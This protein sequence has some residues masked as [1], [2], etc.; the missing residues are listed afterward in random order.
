MDGSTSAAIRTATV[1]ALEADATVT[2]LVPA[3]RIFDSDMV[4]EG[5]D[6]PFI[7]VW[8]TGERMRPAGT[9]TYG[10]P[11][12]L[13]ETELVVDYEAPETGGE[14]E[15]R[16]DAAAA[17][18]VAALMSSGPWMSLWDGG[19]PDCDWRAWRSSDGAK[20]YGTISISLTVRHLRGY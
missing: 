3:A 8:V 19:L 15:S 4:P 13:V 20:L 17:A 12:M 5:D 10:L 2:A 11:I 9:Q 1:T 18:I 16:L 7:N 14:V 6:S